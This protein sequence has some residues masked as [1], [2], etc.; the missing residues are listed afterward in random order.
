[1]TDTVVNNMT[2]AFNS[3]LVDARCKPVISMLEDIRIY[4]MKR[5]QSKRQK[6]EKM[7]GQICPK[8]NSRLQEESKK[9]RYW[10]PRYDLFKC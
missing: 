10:I 4:M 3:V 8:I 7:E 5:W 9:S 1:V 2:E 6:L